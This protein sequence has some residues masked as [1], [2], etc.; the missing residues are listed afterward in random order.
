MAIPSVDCWTSFTQIHDFMKQWL[1]TSATACLVE[2]GF[3]F[4]RSIHRGPEGERKL[5]TRSNHGEGSFPTDPSGMTS[6]PLH[7]FHTPR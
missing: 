1:A 4:F 5:P 2:M 6:P 3:C 7:C